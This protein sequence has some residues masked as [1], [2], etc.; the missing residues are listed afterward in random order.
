MN[1]K[2]SSKEKKSDANQTPESSRI[3]QVKEISKKIEKTES[4]SA[5][6]RPKKNVS[7]NRS[8]K[9]ITKSMLF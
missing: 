2:W 3:D 7:A 1:V 8:C 4:L 5:L 9:L 6:P